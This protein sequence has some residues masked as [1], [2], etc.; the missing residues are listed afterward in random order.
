MRSARSALTLAL[1]IA[2]AAFPLPAAASDVE[3][4]ADDGEIR[5]CV[6]WGAEAEPPKPNNDLVGVACQFV[7]VR[8]DADTETPKAYDPIEGD[9]CTVAGMADAAT[10]PPENEPFALLHHAIRQ[11]QAD[12]DA[13]GLTTEPPAP[14]RW[15]ITVA[16]PNHLYYAALGL[17]RNT[18]GVVSPGVPGGIACLASDA[19]LKN[20]ATL[21]VVTKAVVC[22]NNQLRQR[23][24]IA[25]A[26]RAASSAPQ[27][28]TGE[29]AL[30]MAARMLE[31][32]LAIGRALPVETTP[33]DIYDRLD[34]AAGN[35]AG[36][37]QESL[38]PL[39]VPSKQAKN[40]A[41]VYRLVFRCLRLS[42]VLEVKRNIERRQR[43]TLALSQWHGVDVAP[44]APSLQ[45]NIVKDAGS[46]GVDLAHVYD[47]ATL[48]AAQLG[49]IGDGGNREAVRAV[50]AHARPP[51]ATLSDVF[52]LAIALEAQ[53]MKMT[54]ITGASVGRGTG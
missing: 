29:S 50:R 17:L 5:V 38:P 34:D 27:R 20:A 16:G 7:C 18:S 32:L 53:L 23:L 6:R 26:A 41:D 35:L 48:L 24:G 13:S 37:A 25:V 10:D 12:I 46:A 49:A 4:A 21:N 15:Q 19:P 28:A 44:N 30:R 43:G 14:L 52:G 39:P 42:Q 8:W 22:V 45:I 36:L 9:A 3:D 1:A 47:L 33:S 40:A 54:G 2:L 31:R 11:L 51:E